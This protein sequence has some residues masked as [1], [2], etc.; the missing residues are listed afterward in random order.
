MKKLILLILV[1]AVGYLAYS[2]PDFDTHKAVIGEQLPGR[3]M[4]YA[5]DEA[6]RFRD[7]DYSNFLI[8]SATKDSVKMT[9]VSYG[10]FGRV[11]I[12]DEDWRPKA[13]P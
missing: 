8:A 11:K 9:M 10:F 4:S 1:A 13:T 12:V 6:D 7:L 3:D 2:N 5:R